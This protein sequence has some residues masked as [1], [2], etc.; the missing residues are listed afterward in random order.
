MEG[1]KQKTKKG[2]ALNKII[3]INSEKGVSLI[4][5]LI[6]FAILAIVVLGFNAMFLSGFK[7]IRTARDYSIASNSARQ[8][9][10]KVKNT[11]YDVI[12]SD[13]EKGITVEPIYEGGEEIGKTVTV[14]KEQNEKTVILKTQIYNY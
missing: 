6:A 7:G 10:E 3:N 1:I 2:S 4:E 13:P 12:V 14:T 9:M 5:L 8:E 11:A